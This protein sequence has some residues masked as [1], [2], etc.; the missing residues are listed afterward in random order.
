MKNKSSIEIGK[1]ASALLADLERHN[2]TPSLTYRTRAHK[3]NCFKAEDVKAAFKLTLAA[4]PDVD[5]SE[6]RLRVMAIGKVRS[7]DAMNWQIDDL[8]NFLQGWV[9][10]GQLTQERAEEEAA[11]ADTQ[12]WVCFR[13]VG[14]TSRIR[15]YNKAWPTTALCQR[16]VDGV[17]VRCALT[18]EDAIS[19]QEYPEYLECNEEGEP[20]QQLKMTKPEPKE[21]YCRG[22]SGEV[23]RLLPGKEFADMW[24]GANWRESVTTVEFMLGEIAVGRAVECDEPKPVKWV[25]FSLLADDGALRRYDANSDDNQTHYKTDAGQWMDSVLTKK[26]AKTRIKRGTSA[27]TNVNGRPLALPEAAG[28]TDPET[29]LTYKVDDNGQIW[30]RQKGKEVFHAAPCVVKVVKAV[31]KLGLV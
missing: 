31:I 23:Y 20:L 4:H 15:R 12:D 29:G 17:W 22:A 5:T 16:L 30:V 24:M 11:K 3:L 27:L 8:I 7:K 10:A 19:L 28:A 21:K 2:F 13:A 26:D 9:R 1:V 6:L 18:V 14:D 25:Y